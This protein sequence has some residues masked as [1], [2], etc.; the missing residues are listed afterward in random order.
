[1]NSTFFGATDEFGATPLPKQ[2]P[3]LGGWDF[4][5]S[6]L[7]IDGFS[8]EFGG[9]LIKLMP[10]HQEGSQRWDANML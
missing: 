8:Y 3:V 7:K 10:R 6:L 9:W 2:P 4:R 1:M 5:K